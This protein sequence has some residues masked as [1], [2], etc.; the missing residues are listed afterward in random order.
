[1]S[2]LHW[3]K[4]RACSASCCERGG[5]KGRECLFALEDRT[6][7]WRLARASKYLLM[8]KIVEVLFMNYILSL[9]NGEN[10]ET[11]STPA[12]LLQENPL[13]RPF[14]QTFS[15]SFGVLLSPPPSTYLIP[16]SIVL[17]D[18]KSELERQLKFKSTDE[19]FEE[20]S[21]S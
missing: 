19:I 16:C 4:S 8:A 20:N 15:A 18:L 2:V 14:L 6:Y 9:S 13:P 10:G 11:S 21:Q 12:L 5:T 7:S 17:A 3:V 1:M